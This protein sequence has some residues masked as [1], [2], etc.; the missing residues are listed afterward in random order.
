MVNL[1]VDDGD[2]KRTHREYLFSHNFQYFG[3]SVASHPEY[4]F[5]TVIDYFRDILSYKNKEKDK[6]F[7]EKKSK[8]I[9]FF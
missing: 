5:C 3:F 8:K 1:L 9:Y 2:E 6:I 4:E 7:Q